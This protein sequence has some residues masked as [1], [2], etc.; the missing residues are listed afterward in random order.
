MKH[1]CSMLRLAPLLAA[2][3]LL[4]A[5]SPWSTYP[6]VEVKTATKLTRETW[7]PVPTVMAAAVRYARDRFTPDEDLPVNLP[8][9]TPSTVYDKVFAKLGYGR[10]LLN[11]GEKAVH[12]T[13]VRTR[14][15]NAQV[16]LV[17]TKPTGMNQLVTLTLT[18]TLVDPWHVTGSR[19]WQLRD[20]TVPA[21]NYVPPPVVD[22]KA[23]PAEE[24]P[25]AESPEGS[26]AK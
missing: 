8:E 26:E 11:A 6:P 19:P 14:G 12:V 7:E 4:T 20:F 22:D 21:P 2:A 15:F 24:P 1:G 25:S 13:E 10:P 9:G 17:Y 5:C 16:D 3:S 18:R 23:A